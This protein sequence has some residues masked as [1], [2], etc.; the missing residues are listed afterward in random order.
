KNGFIGN[1]SKRLPTRQL[2]PG[3]LHFYH[4]LA[5]LLPVAVAGKTDFAAHCATIHYPAATGQQAGK[6]R[7]AFEKPSKQKQSG[8]SGSRRRPEWAMSAPVGETPAANERASTQKRSG[9][10]YTRG[11][12]SGTNWKRWTNIVAP[13]TQAPET[14]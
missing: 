7:P 14:A 2:A 6:D 4:T 3:L 10:M 11:F 8:L 5:S 9:L 1:L 13:R 12:P